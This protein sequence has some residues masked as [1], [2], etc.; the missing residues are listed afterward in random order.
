VYDSGQFSD[1]VLKF[2]SSTQSINAHKIFLAQA[3]T[4]L[5]LMKNMKENQKTL[6]FGEEVSF[7][8]MKAIVKY[9]YSG[10]MSYDLNTDEKGKSAQDGKEKFAVLVSE[11]ARKSGIQISDSDVCT[12]DTLLPNNLSRALKSFI[13]KKLFSDVSLVCKSPREDGPEE[14]S[15]NVHKVILCARSS[16]FKAMFSDGFMESSQKQIE[17]S[18]RPAVFKLLLAYMYTGTVDISADESVELLMTAN[19]YGLEHLKQLCEQFIER[20]IDSDNVAWLFE[21]AEQNDAQQLKKF[22]LYFILRHFDSVSATESYANLSQ[23]TLDEIHQ[24]RKPIVEGATPNNDSK[25]SVQ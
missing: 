23:Q 19:E 1:I 22:C 18:I 17:I 5:D 7:D 3:S 13:T 16:K 8:V 24:Y 6:K 11:A 2:Q 9:L 12:P 25:C 21:I 20:G 15:V 14:E 4:L 10:K